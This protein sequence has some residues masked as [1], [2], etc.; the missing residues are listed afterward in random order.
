MSGHFSQESVFEGVKEFITS[1]PLLV[2]G[3]IIGGWFGG[4]VG[5][6]IGSAIGGI[7]G[8]LDLDKRKEIIDKGFEIL[9]GI[10]DGVMKNSDKISEFIEILLSK[11]GEFIGKNWDKFVKLGVQIGWAIIKGVV[12]GLAKLYIGSFDIGQ[13]IGNLF[14]GG[15]YSIPYGETGGIMPHTGLAYLHKGEMITP[16]NE[17]SNTVAP[18]INISANISSDYDVR[19]LAEELKRYWVTDM[20]RVS[21]GRGV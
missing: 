4:P 15:G 21:Q 14:M 11:L 7:F 17:V 13:K 10:I 12:K 5:A 2:V 6:M 19:R 16:A 18:T 9:Q 1:N 3:A 8:K 20:E